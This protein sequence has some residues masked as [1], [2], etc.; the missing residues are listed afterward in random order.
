M[1][2]QAK[3]KTPQARRILL[4]D[5][6]ADFVA[7]FGDFLQTHRPGAWAVHT[8]ANYNEALARLKEHSFNLVVLDIQMPVM[9]GMQFLTLLK[10]SYPGLQVII[11]SGM[12]TPENRNY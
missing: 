12:A 2:E 5:D 11:L 7:M 8:A 6:D 3:T 1:T 9:D 4:V 10:R